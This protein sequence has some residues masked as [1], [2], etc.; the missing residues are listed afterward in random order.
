MS[1]SVKVPALLE[2]WVRA[3]FAPVLP[4]IATRGCPLKPDSASVAPLAMLVMPPLPNSRSAEFESDT[5]PD[6]IAGA[7]PAIFRV[8]CAEALPVRLSVPAF[9]N[10]A[11][12]TIEAAV[13]W[14]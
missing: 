12:V 11:A 10:P 14:L 13:S 2:S 3:L 7:G 6:R 9:D 5:L 8:A 1:N 4:A